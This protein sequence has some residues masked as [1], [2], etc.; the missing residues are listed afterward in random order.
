MTEAQAR[1]EHNL[2]D[3]LAQALR[4]ALDAQTRQAFEAG[5]NYPRGLAMNQ[6]DYENQRAAAYAA[7]LTDRASHDRS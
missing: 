6:C 5:Y 4:A 3:Q 1:G 7:Y 2:L